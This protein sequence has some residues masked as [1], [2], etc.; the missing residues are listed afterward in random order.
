MN[1]P[2]P[3][4]TNA[5]QLGSEP[6]SVKRNH[7]E[8]YIHL[9]AFQ[10]VLSHG[11]KPLLSIPNAQRD[12]LIALSVEAQRFMVLCLPSEYRSTGWFN[13]I[14]QGKRL[15]LGFAGAYTCSLDIMQT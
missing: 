5:P 4:K 15:K 9:P 11:D 10:S 2:A 12:K 13:V 3:T 6:Q 14:E 1:T 7:I 8:D